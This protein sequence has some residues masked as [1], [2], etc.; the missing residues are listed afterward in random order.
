MKR[1]ITLQEMHS[2]TTAM[3]KLNIIEF[4]NGE[5]ELKSV[6]KEISELFQES[7]EYST[8]QL[9]GI[10]T[11]FKEQYVRLNTIEGKNAILSIIIIEFLQHLNSEHNV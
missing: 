6:V 10:L 7:T 9:E 2:C 1:R 4:F 3:F 8:T 11:E 5:S